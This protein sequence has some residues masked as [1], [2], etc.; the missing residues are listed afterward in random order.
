MT[1]HTT[2]AKAYPLTWPP[3]VARTTNPLVA[4]FHRNVEVRTATSHYKR[5]ADLLV[6]EEYAGLVSELK[7]IKA[8]NVVVSTNIPTKNDGTPWGDR[9]PVGG[10]AAVAVYWSLRERRQGRDELVPHSI[11][12]DRWST[13]A[14]NLHAISL[15]LEA[16]RGVQRWGAVSQHQV[17]RGF[18]ALPAGDGDEM[19]AAPVRRTWREVL[20]VPADGWTLQAPPAAVLAF[21]KSQYKALAARFHH[22]ANADEAAKERLIE[23][24]VAMEDAEAELDPREPEP[25]AAP[26]H[27]DES[28]V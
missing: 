18:R 9:K 15:T 17:L 11:Q 27:I 6:S 20:E 28:R 4:K 22:D 8:L 26:E 23:I 10:D 24:N 14:D 13:V 12:S 21:A 7:R 19:N 5:A 1:N 3:G 16:L 25:E 2:A